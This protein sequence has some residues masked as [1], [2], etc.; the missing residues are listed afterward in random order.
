VKQCGVAV[1]ETILIPPMSAEAFHVYA[2]QTIR[3]IDS[4][5]GQPGDFVAFRAD[6]FSVRFS[7]ARSRVENGRVRVTADDRLWTNAFP[8]EVMF[9]ITGDTFGI[10]DLLY[11]PCCRHALKNR[12]SVSRDGCQEKLAAALGAWGILPQQVPDPLNIFFHVTVDEGG[13]M[14]VVPPASR[15]GDA[16]ELTACMDCLVAVSTC[17]VPL[18]GKENSGYRVEIGRTRT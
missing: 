3:I 16:I 15:A 18:E 1:T 6:D 4:E 9:S 8:P 11:P 14:A 5:G 12:F 10:H 2:G 13:R 17:S 7:Q